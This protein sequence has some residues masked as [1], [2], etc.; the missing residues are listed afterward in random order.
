MFW[1]FVNL[2]LLNHPGK[3]GKIIEVPRNLLVNHMFIVLRFVD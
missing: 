2:P 3:G 1:Y